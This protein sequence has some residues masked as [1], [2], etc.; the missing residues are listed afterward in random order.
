[1]FETLESRLTPG[2]ESTEAPSKVGPVT[3]HRA[4]DDFDDDDDSKKRYWDS[5]C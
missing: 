4:D 5:L 2:Q 1:M 3:N